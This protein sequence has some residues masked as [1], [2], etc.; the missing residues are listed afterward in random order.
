MHYI[1]ILDYTNGFTETTRLRFLKEMPTATEILK[2]SE[3][4]FYIFA[5]EKNSPMGGYPHIGD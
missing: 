4:E 1:V 5:P 3:A 2:D